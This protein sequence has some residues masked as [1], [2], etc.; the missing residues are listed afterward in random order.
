MIQRI[1]SGWF[2]ARQIFSPMPAEGII[3]LTPERAFVRK[4]LHHVDTLSVQR[5]P[6]VPVR[7]DHRCISFGM[8]K[9]RLAN[10]DVLHRLEAST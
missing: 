8:T 2:S 10:S 7:V 1:G 6:K 5:L 4:Q 9:H 3:G